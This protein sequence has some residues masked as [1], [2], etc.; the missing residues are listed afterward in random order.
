MIA[1]EE[2]SDEEEL[3]LE[4]DPV[5]ATAARGAHSQQR[6]APCVLRSPGRATVLGTVTAYSKLLLNE[7]TVGM[8]FVQE[9]VHKS[10]PFVLATKAR[11]KQTQKQAQLCRLDVDS[12]LETMKVIRDVGR[13]TLTRMAASMA[14]ASR[15]LAALKL[16]SM[17]S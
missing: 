17:V 6:P 10:V 15:S 8:Y 13:P 7:P 1:P 11:V 16:R 3:R 2:E 4:A 12:C 14:S 5:E 9:H